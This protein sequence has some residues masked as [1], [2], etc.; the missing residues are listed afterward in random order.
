MNTSDRYRRWFEYEKDSH[1]KVLASLNS[2]PVQN[3]VA[4]TFKKA[5]DLFAHVI[6]GRRLWL[7]RLGVGKE[8]P[9]DLFPQGFPFEELAPRIQEMEALWAGY[10]A[11]LDDSEV[12]RV[13]EYHSTEGK[14]FRN[15]I[16]DVLT[17]LFGHS[18]YHRGQIATLVRACGG[19]PAATDF[20]F[21]ARESIPSRD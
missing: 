9:R 13:F 18:L 16:E 14:A 5:V 19:E 11:R 12:A 4:A 6:M 17:Q 15:T 10:F 2:V 20:I 1:A 21:W 7:S 3:R 8:P